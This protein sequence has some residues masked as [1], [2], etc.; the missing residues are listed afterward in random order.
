MK[1]SLM[2][3]PH[4]QEALE[5]QFL[6][7]YW[8]AYPNLY[9]YLMMLSLLRLHGIGAG[10]FI[11]SFMSPQSD[12]LATPHLPNINFLPRVFASSCVYEIR[13]VLFPSTQRYLSSVYYLFLSR[14]MFRSYDCLQAEIYT[15]CPRRNVPDFGRV[16]LMVKY[17]DITQNT[18]VQS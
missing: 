16:F 18:Y 13:G 14:Y 2:R 10:H 5:Y 4:N 12:S 11:L 3:Q 6:L 15:G 7:K 1:A 8:C 17:T 9:D